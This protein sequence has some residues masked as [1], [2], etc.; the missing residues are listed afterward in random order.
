MLIPLEGTLFD[1]I[2]GL[3]VHALVVPFAAVLLPLGALLVIFEFASSKLADRL[4]W[5]SVIILAFGA[6]ASWVA[7]ESGQALAARVGEPQLHATLGRVLPFVAIALVVIAAIWLMVRRQALKTQGHQSSGSVGFGVVSLVLALAV[8]ISTLIVAFVGIQAAWGP[9]FSP[10]PSPPGPVP[11]PVLS[12]S[13][14]PPT[15]PGTPTTA[16]GYTM[17]EVA[18]HN[19]ELS[20]WIVVSGQV[21]DIT[22]WLSATSPRRDEVLTL[23]GSDASKTFD[24]STTAP[25][26]NAELA[27]FLIGPLR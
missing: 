21:Y 3:P 18:G 16:S 22:P 5:F 26:S 27:A 9:R 13:V 8:A 14:P 2:A 12:S 4:G 17:T 20:C 1:T 7:G 25:M 23:C 10:I 24:N 11:T 19:D 6:G 15:P